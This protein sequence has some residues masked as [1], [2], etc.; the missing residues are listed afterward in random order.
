M[1]YVITQNYTPAHTELFNLVS[2]INSAYATANQFEYLT[3]NVQT[4]TRAGLWEKIAW[5]N[6]LLPT[7]QD[8]SYVMY[9]DC[10][11]LCLGGDPKTA[12]PAG[13]EYGMVHLRGKHGKNSIINWYNSGVMVM[14]NT[15]LVRTFLQ[16]VWNRNS[17]TDETALNKEI[18]H[19]NNS[20]GNGQPIYSLPVE[21]NC[22]NNNKRIPKHINIKSWH[23]VKYTDKLTEIKAF[24]STLP[25]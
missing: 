6:T 19:L 4:S 3:S 10:D 15:P 5:L 9:M 11:S 24:L 12:L 7:L 20:I 1:Q 16:D 23:G 8:N 14:I 25:K 13:F 18:A 2:P 17:V 22:W 21:W